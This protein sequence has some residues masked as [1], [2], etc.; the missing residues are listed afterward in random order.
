M[1]QEEILGSDERFRCQLL[2]RMCQDVGYV[3]RL[4]KQE[5]DEPS[6]ESHDFRYVVENHL[7]G[8]SEK[9]FLTMRQLIESFPEGEAPEWITLSEVAGWQ[10]ELQEL[11]GLT[12]N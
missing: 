7:W 12:L 4:V 5:L 2:D 11:T 8:G 6:E 10:R 3:T 1:K 9:H